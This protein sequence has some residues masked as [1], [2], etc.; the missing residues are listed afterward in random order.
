MITLPAEVMSA[1][2]TMAERDMKRWVAVRDVVGKGVGVHVADN[3]LVQAIVGWEVEGEA[4]DGGALDGLDD[5]TRKA[6]ARSQ[7]RSRAKEAYQ[8]HNKQRATKRAQAALEPATV[9]KSTCS[10]AHTAGEGDEG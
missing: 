3:P 5:K 6:L 1:M 4:T 2:D 8:H 10:T 7:S 9:S